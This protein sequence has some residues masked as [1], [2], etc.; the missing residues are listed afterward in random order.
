MTASLSLVGAYEF[1]LHRIEPAIELTANGQLFTV[2]GETGKTVRAERR[3]D[4]VTWELVTT[5]PTPTS[6][7]TAID[8]TAATEPFLFYRQ[9]LIP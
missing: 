5:V 1:N 9:V 8:P 6:G 4:L 3:Q 7:Q 2:R